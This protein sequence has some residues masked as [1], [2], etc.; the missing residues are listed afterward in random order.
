LKEDKAMARSSGV[1]TQNY[2]A[3]DH[4]SHLYQIASKRLL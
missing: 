2:L 3:T 4:I 1:K